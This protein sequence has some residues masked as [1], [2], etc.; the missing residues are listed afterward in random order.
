MAIMHAFMVKLLRQAMMGRIP[1]LMCFL[2]GV[3]GRLWLCPILFAIKWPLFPSLP[4]L[5]SATSLLNGLSSLA[6]QLWSQLPGTSNPQAWLPGARV[7]VEPGL[8]E[9]LHQAD[10]W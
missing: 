7:C 10:K 5:E 3:H 2:P 1:I 8:K 6:F 4:A 9:E